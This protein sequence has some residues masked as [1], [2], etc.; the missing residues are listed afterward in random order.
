[1]SKQQ[2]RQTRIAI[3]EV[4]AHGLKTGNEA[5]VLIGE[6]GKKVDGTIVGTKDEVRPDEALVDE[7]K[8]SIHNH[9]TSSPFS[10]QDIY[11]LMLDNRHDHMFVIGHDGTM[12]RMSRTA[13]TEEHDPWSFN[14]KYLDHVERFRPEFTRR[15]TAGEDSMKANNI[16]F[17]KAV[18]SLAEDLDLDYKVVKP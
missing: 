2:R 16:C 9:P 12:Y 17:A 14:Q 3:G 1:L 7:S 6:D 13:Q 8:I 11:Y 10:R 4:L 15:V 5:L 18:A